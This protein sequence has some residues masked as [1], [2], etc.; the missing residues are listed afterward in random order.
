MSGSA[1]PEKFP[2]ASRKSESESIS[3]RRPGSP[4]GR[5]VVHWPLA[6][7]SKLR[8]NARREMTATSAPAQSLTDSFLDSAAAGIV[9]NAA[10]RKD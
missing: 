5:A 2:R 3:K 6:R 10:D 9:A 1:R 7:I 8:E 4:R